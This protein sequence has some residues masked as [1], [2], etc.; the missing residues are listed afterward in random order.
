ML[1]RFAGFTVF[2]GFFCQTGFF[3]LKSKNRF[4]VSENFLSIQTLVSQSNQQLTR[5]PGVNCYVHTQRFV[6]LILA[7]SS[8]P[9]LK[10]PFNFPFCENNLK[11]ITLIYTNL[12]KP[13]R[14]HML[15]RKILEDHF[16]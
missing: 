16:S 11:K 13:G 12:C 8:C 6:G 9:W 1:G 2:F 10:I 3:L 7:N 4:F 5:I 14:T 15:G